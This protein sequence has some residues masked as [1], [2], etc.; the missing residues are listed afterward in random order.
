MRKYRSVCIKPG[1]WTVMYNDI[2]FVSLYT[3][4]LLYFWTVLTSRL[5]SILRTCVCP[6]SNSLIDNTIRAS[7]SC[8]SCAWTSLYRCYRKINLFINSII[9]KYN[10]LRLIDTLNM[11]RNMPCYNLVNK[12]NFR[13]LYTQSW[14]QCEINEHIYNIITTVIDM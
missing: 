10:I 14:R 9:F 6:S 3:I 7:P 12:T 11:L 8:L 13:L 4:L 1:E 5:N 2:D